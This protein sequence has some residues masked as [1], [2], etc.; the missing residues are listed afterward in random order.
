MLLGKMN[1]IIEAVLQT[2]PK[3]RSNRENFNGHNTFPT[4]HS[5]LTCDHG[6]AHD[7]RLSLAQIATDICVHYERA[8]HRPTN[9]ITSHLQWYE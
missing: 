7:H 3:P 6:L 4:L 9:H 2:K 5:C 1:C 8:T